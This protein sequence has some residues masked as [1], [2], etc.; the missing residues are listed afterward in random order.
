MSN[1]TITLKATID[2]NNQLGVRLIDG[3]GDSEFTGLAKIAEANQGVDTITVEVCDFYANRA[4]YRV[5]G[6]VL[7]ED[8][9]TISAHWKANEAGNGQC[10][11]FASDRLSAFII[12]ARPARAGASEPHPFDSSSSGIQPDLDLPTPTK[13]PKPVGT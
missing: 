7:A 4:I 8:G 2:R 5:Y 12:G 1:K 3:R 11:T 6:A 13:D 9:Q 10:Y